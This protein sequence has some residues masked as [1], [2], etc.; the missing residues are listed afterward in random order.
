MTDLVHLSDYRRRSRAR[1]YFSRA[2]LS[3]LLGLYSTRVMRGEWRDWHANR[4][5]EATAQ[6]SAALNAGDGESGEALA[7]YAQSAPPGHAM[8]ARFYAA[9]TQAKTGDVAA[10]VAAYD[11]IAADAALEPVYRDLAALL[12]VLHQVE[13]GDPAALRARLAPLLEPANPWRFTAKELTALLAVRTGDKAQ[14]R[15]LFDELAQDPVAPLGV[16]GRAADLA[17]L[18]ATNG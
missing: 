3:Q 14:A 5:A 11:Q 4:L 2:E 7:Q 13:T 17:A 1:V 10:A 9:G 8:L 18:Y 16:R 6:L 12:A 15:T